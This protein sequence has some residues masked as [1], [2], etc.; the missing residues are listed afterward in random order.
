LLGGH[1]E[2]GELAIIGHN[3][4]SGTGLGR[5]PVPLPA[6]FVQGID[7][8]I[9]DFDRGAWSYLRGEWK[10]DGWWYY[11]F[12]AL[13]VKI[14]LGCF[15]LLFSAVFATVSSGKYSTHW[16]YEINL[17]I[18]LI[19]L[20]ALISIHSGFSVH[21]RYAIPAIPFAIVWVSKIARC[22]QFRHCGAVATSGL[23]LVW[24]VASSLS[25]HPH[26]LS[27]FNELAGGPANGGKH[28][29]DSNIA[30]GQDLYFLSRWY[31]D[32]PHARPFHLAHFGLVDPR[33]FGI[34]FSLPLTAVGSPNGFTVPTRAESFPQDESG[35]L[36]GWYAID[37]NHLYGAPYC[38]DDGEGGLKWLATHGMDLTYFQEFTPAARAGYSIYVYHITEND[39]LLYRKLHGLR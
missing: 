23:A 10:K 28:L 7:S 26:G 21:S 29:L 31:R 33:L 2:P 16:Y 9:S 1:R 30:W 25:Y 4:F 39:A 38:A 34:D 24:A 18:P 36:P 8:Q 11:Y 22:A 19:A 5:I 12:Y 3:R 13:M 27:Y 20:L 37:V 32:H 35:P 15:V 14:P 17:L 6:N